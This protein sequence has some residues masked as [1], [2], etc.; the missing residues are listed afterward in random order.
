M[1]G[2][3]HQEIFIQFLGPLIHPAVQF[4]PLFQ[5]QIKNLAGLAN[6][7]N[8]G[9]PAFIVPIYIFDS[10]IVIHAAVCLV[11]CDHGCKNVHIVTSFFELIIIPLPTVGNTN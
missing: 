10:R 11:G 8:S 7:E 5:R 6:R 4:H 9:D 2:R 1:S 3:N